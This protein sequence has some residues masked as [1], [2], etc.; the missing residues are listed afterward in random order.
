MKM[1]LLLITVLLALSAVLAF[2][3]L[4]RKHEGVHPSSF[5]PE[6]VLFYVQQKELGPIIENLGQNRL[7]ETIRSIDIVRLALDIEVPVATVDKI[8]TVYEFLQSPSARAIYD[9]FFSKYFAVAVLPHISQAPGKEDMHDN[10]IFFSEPRHGNALLETAAS[11][12]G[13]DMQISS[14]QYG[15]HLIYRIPLGEEILSFVATGRLVVASLQEK[16]LRR[17]LDR[18]DDNK[19]NLRE[20]FFYS[21]LSQKYRQSQLFCYFSVAGIKQQLQGLL[22]DEIEGH[23]QILKHLGKLN[24][25]TSAGFGT[26]RKKGYSRNG[27]TFHF[28]KYKLNKRTAAQFSTKPEFNRNIIRAPADSLL[29]YWT[30][31]LNIAALWDIYIKESGITDA[32]SAEIEESVAGAADIEFDDLLRLVGNSLH[33]MVSR[34]ATVDLVPVPNFALTVSILDDDKARTA[35][36]NIFK[37]SLIPHKSEIYRGIL[38]TYWGNEMQKGLQPV[39][40]FYNDALYISSSIKMQ[41]DI[42]DTIKDGNSIVESNQFKQYGKDLLLPNNAMVFAQIPDLL[43]TAETLVRWSGTIMGLQSRKTAY[44]S[45]KVIDDFILPL[46]GGFKEH[47]SAITSRSYFEESKVIIESQFITVPRNQ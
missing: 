3:L 20:N 40:T 4:Y 45:K 27:M 5:L 31:T 43:E 6:N 16:T 38:F 25:F 9:E 37:K 1:R 34:P 29:Y 19:I 35:F 13:A 39:F 23:R 42:I 33:L 14:I 7:I 30:N 21:E 44:M 22:H 8:R 41:Q 36:H 26:D 10:V 12:K 28:N 17:A 24:G 18:F 47:Y 2:Y 15:S 32:F 11:L 46:L